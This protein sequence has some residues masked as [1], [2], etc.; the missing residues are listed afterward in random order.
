MKVL[1]YGA[2]VIGTLY[3]SRLQDEGHQVTIWRATQGLQTSDAMAWC[4]RMS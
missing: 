2:G 1:V 4:W 3:A